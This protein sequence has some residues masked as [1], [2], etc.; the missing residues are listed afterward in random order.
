MAISMVIV[1][2]GLVAPKGESILR[3]SQQNAVAAAAG[4]TQKNHAP[5]G[6]SGGMAEEKEN[7]S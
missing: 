2:I 1:R 5:G 4:Q 3:F 7:N 6:W